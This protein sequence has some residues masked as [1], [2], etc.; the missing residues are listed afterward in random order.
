[1]LLLIV[2]YQTVKFI[3]L[4]PWY[5]SSDTKL[6]NLLLSYPGTYRQIGTQIRKYMG[7][8]YCEG[9]GG[10]WGDS[11]MAGRVLGNCDVTRYH[12]RKRE[13]MFFTKARAPVKTGALYLS[14]LFCTVIY[15]L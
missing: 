3:T 14:L 13:C 6:L 7:K 9:D 4:L 1:M 10:D 11:K 8:I 12:R 15:S 2:R 5:L